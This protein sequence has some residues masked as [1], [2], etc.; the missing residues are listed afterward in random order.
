MVGAILDASWMSWRSNFPL[1]QHE[2]WVRNKFLAPENY[3]E[4]EI[5]YCKMYL[6]SLL[7]VSVA[8]VKEIHFLSTEQKK[9][10]KNIDVIFSL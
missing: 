8:I 10:I 2:P 7:G 1:G 9:I 5:S 6:D 4:M 3:Q